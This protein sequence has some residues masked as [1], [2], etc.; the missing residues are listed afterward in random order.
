MES[1]RSDVNEDAFV[2]AY[3]AVQVASLENRPSTGDEPIETTGAALSQ[4]RTN[5]DGSVSYN[6]EGVAN[7]KK[8]SSKKS[9]TKKAAKK[10]K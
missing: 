8:T 9:T 1:P 4:R 7:A 10:K 6:E 5:A 3:D 2:P